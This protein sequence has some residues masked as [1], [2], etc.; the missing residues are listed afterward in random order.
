ML[1]IIIV[2][3]DVREFIQGVV[4]NLTARFPSSEIIQ[5]ARIFDPKVVPS[6][7]A[8]CA[9]YGEGDL[10]LLT[11]QYSSFVDHNQC[12][13]EW[14]TLKHCMKMNY[15]RHSFREFVL[16]LPLISPLLCTILHFQNLQK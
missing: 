9:A 15:S 14:D 5:E 10:Q 13:L 2:E 11:I 12:S 1:P 7:D 8:D 16:K 4:D 3:K 6:L